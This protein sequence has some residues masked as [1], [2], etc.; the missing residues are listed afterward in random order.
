MQMR[1][2]MQVQ[3]TQQVHQEMQLRQLPHGLPAKPKPSTS[4]FTA[5]KSGSQ[6]LARSYKAR[7]TLSERGRSSELRLR[8]KLTRLLKAQSLL[9][10]PSLLCLCSANGQQTLPTA[11]F[12]GSLALC[13]KL[14]TE[15]TTRRRG[16]LLK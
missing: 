16:F 12:I 11:C 8:M 7:L 15:T 3:K 14:T 2:Q 9:I 10:S 5:L 1:V 4:G 13:S 6:C